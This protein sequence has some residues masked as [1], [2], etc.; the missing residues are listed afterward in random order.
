MTSMFY[1]YYVSSLKQYHMQNIG[2]NSKL[3]SALYLTTLMKVTRH[4]FATVF[5][6]RKSGCWI[7]KSDIFR[8]FNIVYDDGKKDG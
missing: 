1:L 8:R 4:N 6:V 5:V 3:L 7:V 2:K